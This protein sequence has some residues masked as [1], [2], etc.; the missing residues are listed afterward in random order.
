MAKA[1]PINSLP[2]ENNYNDH[3][4]TPS[5]AYEHLASVILPLITRTSSYTI[6]DPYYCSG[7]S[8]P[9]LKAALSTAPCSTVEVINEPRDFYKDVENKTTP[10]CDFI[11]TN[12]PYSDD[13]KT[14]CFAFLIEQLAGHHIDGYAVLLPSYCVGRGY[15]RGALPKLP[16]THTE[17]ILRPP[18]AYTYKHPEDTGYDSPPFYSVWICAVPVAKVGETRRA[19]EAFAGA[20][21][22]VF[23]TA[24]SLKAADTAECPFGLE[25]RMNSKARKRLKRRLGADSAGVAAVSEKYGNNQAENNKKAKM[26]TTQSKEQQGGGKVEQKSSSGGSKYRDETG[27]RIKKRF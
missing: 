27:A 4:Q 21:C 10:N 7:S 16:S 19:V 9:L 14:K 8:V 20:S 18:S 26:G 2:F 1:V 23:T 17:L 3:F 11:V 25:K 12:P 5:I 6:Y 24:D 22:Q 13:H 15:Y